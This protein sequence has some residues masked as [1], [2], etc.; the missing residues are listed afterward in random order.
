MFTRIN[1]GFRLSSPILMGLALTA[2]GGGGGGGGDDLTTAP[3]EQ[4]TTELQAGGYVTEIAFEDGTTVGA[5][6]LLSPTGEFVVLVDIDDITV[7]TLDFGSGGTIT[8]SGTDYVFDG[9]SW[10]T[11][12]GTISGEATSETTATITATAP[13]YESVS[14]LERDDQY[15]DLGVTLAGLSGTYT[16]SAPGI[17]TTSVTIASDGII[18]GSDE[19]GCVFNG[20]VAIPDPSI[21]V[22]EVTYSANNCADSQRNGD[23]SGLGAYDPDIGEIQFAG[24][25]NQAASFFIGTK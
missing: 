14:T 9:T 20:N 5:A 18:T 17:F 19:T 25:G 15:S 6:T 1:T 2:C 10:Q 8:G 12:G 21:N 16:M 3:P 22:Y 24:A 13:G 7:G 23:Y 4:P 11:Q